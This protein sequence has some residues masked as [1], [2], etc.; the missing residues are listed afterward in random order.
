MKRNLLAFAVSG[1]VFL[2]L[3][4]W[5]ISSQR[6]APPPAPVVTAERQ[7]APAPPPLDQARVAALEQQASAEPRNAD[8]RV[9]LANLYFDADRF[10]EAAP[11]YE[12]A[13]K[14]DPNHVRAATDLAVVYFYMGDM[15]RASTQIDRAVAAN[16]RHVKALLNQGI[17]RAFGKQDLAGA[18][19]SWER[20]IAVAPNSEEGRL[21]RQGLEGLRSAHQPAEGQ[22]GGAGD[23]RSP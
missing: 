11:W 4:G 19:Q 17:I 3:V 10:D 9:D 1:P 14:I 8:V 12:A 6:A 21:A 2:L 7:A 13:L 16:P 5:I 22:G 23:E 20:V 18:A 15:D